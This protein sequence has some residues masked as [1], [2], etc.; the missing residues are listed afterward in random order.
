MIGSGDIIPSTFLK[1]DGVA[2]EFDEIRDCGSSLLG[3][4][5]NLLVGR[6]RHCERTDDKSCELIRGVGWGSPQHEAAARGIAAVHPKWSSDDYPGMGLPPA[7]YWSDPAQQLQ[8]VFGTLEHAFGGDYPQDW[9][10]AQMGV[11][12]IRRFRRRCVRVRPQE[13]RLLD[14]LCAWKFSKYKRQEY[15]VFAQNLECRALSPIELFRMAMPDGKDAEVC[16]AASYLY[17]LEYQAG[18]A[19]YIEQQ[20]RAGELLRRYG[21][22]RNIG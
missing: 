20:G 13:S 6:F 9:E 21:Y 15:L 19:A 18:G 2:E 12:L 16:L 22:A 11:L 1:N 7:S 8:E 5:N 4:R 14:S 10:H 3:E 17:C